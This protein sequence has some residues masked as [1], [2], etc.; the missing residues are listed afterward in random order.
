VQQGVVKKF[1]Q[2]EKLKLK[3]SQQ[4]ETTKLMESNFDPVASL[5]PDLRALCYE[6]AYNF[7]ETTYNFLET[8]TQANDSLL[9]RLERSSSK[10]ESIG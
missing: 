9:A 2:P 10:A 1:S 3:D 8:A 4:A 5:S 7:H 6:A